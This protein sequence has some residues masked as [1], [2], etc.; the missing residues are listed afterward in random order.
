MVVA[1]LELWAE[2]LENNSICFFRLVTVRILF[3]IDDYDDENYKASIEKSAHSMTTL[4]QMAQK[5]L[6]RS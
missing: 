5:T 1:I 4:P 3:S 6:S 2:K